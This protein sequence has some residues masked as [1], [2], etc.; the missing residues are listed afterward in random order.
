LFWKQSQPQKAPYE[1][2][3][4]HLMEAG[5]ALF[6]LA[7]LAAMTAGAGPVTAFMDAA[8]REV[9][10]TAGYVRAVLPAPPEGGE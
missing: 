7:V 10:D 5:P 6:L 2:D 1:R 9:F 8:S 4:P 3:A